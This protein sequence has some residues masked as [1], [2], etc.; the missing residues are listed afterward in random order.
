MERHQADGFQSDMLNFV[1][2]LQILGI[3][4]QLNKKIV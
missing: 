1:C 4:D 3:F 2:L